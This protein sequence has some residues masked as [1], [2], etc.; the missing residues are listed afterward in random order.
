MR[1]SLIEGPGRSASTFG[2]Y[3]VPSAPDAVSR[4]LACHCYLRATPLPRY[5]LLNKLGESYRNAASSRGRLRSS[6]RRTGGGRHKRRYT[7]SKR[8]YIW[9]LNEHQIQ[10]NN[11]ILNYLMVENL[12]QAVLA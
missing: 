7:L 3:R 10:K 9:E 1:Y 2:K 5:Q 8:M 11:I 12:G 6:R 4:L